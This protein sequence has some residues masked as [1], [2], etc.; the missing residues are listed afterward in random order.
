MRFDLEKLDVQLAASISF[1]MHS[2]VFPSSDV[3]KR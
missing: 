1:T 3:D 2:R